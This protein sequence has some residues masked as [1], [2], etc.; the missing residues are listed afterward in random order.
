MT[1]RRPGRVLVIRGLAFSM[2]ALALPVYGQEVDFSALVRYGEACV[3]LKAAILT[4]AD[5]ALGLD[6]HA[7]DWISDCNNIPA[8]QDASDAIRAAKKASP[9]DCLGRVQSHDAASAAYSLYQ[10]KVPVLPRC[11]AR[12]C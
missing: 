6:A 11:I 1:L 10:E 5:E 7:V 9:L 2:L 12:R 8:C 4:D 3:K